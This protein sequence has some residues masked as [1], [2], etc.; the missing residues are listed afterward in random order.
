MP[1]YTEVLP[2]KYI[3][4]GP[5]FATQLAGFVFGGAWPILF[6]WL[7]FGQNSPW[8][9]YIAVCSLPLALLIFLA[10]P[11]FDE[12]AVF[13]ASKGKTKQAEKILQKYAKSK[14]SEL[15]INLTV[16]DQNGDKTEENGEELEL[17]PGAEIVSTFAK[18]LFRSITNW[19]MMRKFI[20]IVMIG[21]TTLTTSYASNL[22]VE[23][24]LFLLEKVASF[25]PENDYLKLL[26]YQLTGIIPLILLA[27]ILKSI[28][29]RFRE[30]F[31]LSIFL[32]RPE[33]PKSLG[34]NGLGV[35]RAMVPLTR[36]ALDPKKRSM[37]LF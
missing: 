3:W 16:I 26:V 11:F 6:G 21:T 35:P 9:V 8:Q 7:I 19:N 33:K 28:E 24:L 13:L 20:C 29:G 1:Y 2:K 14:R 15:L 34:M 32:T 18:T 12:S 31:P 36:Y 27:F 5:L 22:I 23:H 17:M 30:V 10:V 4:I 25:T 37:F